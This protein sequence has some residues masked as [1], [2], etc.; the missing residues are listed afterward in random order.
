MTPV[1]TSNAPVAQSP[2]TD[3][4]TGHPSY[5]HTVYAA[6]IQQPAYSNQYVVSSYEQYPQA[7]VASVP[8]PVV[9]PS[10]STASLP[11]TMQ[12]L[13]KSTNID[14]LSGL[15]FALSDLS[16]SAAQPLMPTSVVVPV[17]PLAATTLAPADT[18]EIIRPVPAPIESI[19]YALL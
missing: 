2:A 17:A 11:P 5:H 8:P 6:D 15:D 14:L 19:R 16:L 4:N 7:P 18:T 10:T 12:S 1:V 9:V 13:K 3:N